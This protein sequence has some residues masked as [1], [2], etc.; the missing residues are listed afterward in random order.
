MGGGGE[1][2]VPLSLAAA[3]LGGLVSDGPTRAPCT[4]GASHTQPGRP[5]LNRGAP[6]STGAPH[7]GLGRPT[8]G[9]GIAPSET[10]AGVRAEITAAA[11]AAAVEAATQAQQL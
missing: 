6:H 2:G 4:A 9:C 7:T 3:K 10:R 8:L 11:A 1:G 5:T